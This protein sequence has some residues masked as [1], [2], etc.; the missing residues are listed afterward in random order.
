LVLDS[1]PI[2]THK[3]AL[4]LERHEVRLQINSAFTGSIN[5]NACA[6][7]LHAAVRQM[8]RDVIKGYA[9][10]YDSTH[11]QYVAAARIEFA[12]EHDLALASVTMTSNFHEAATDRTFKRAN[13]VREKHKSVIEYSNDREI[14]NLLNS[15]DFIRNLIY[16]RADFFLRF[17]HSE[18]GSHCGS[19]EDSAD[20]NR[21]IEARKIARLGISSCAA[22][23][24][25]GGKP[26][27]QM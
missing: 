24:A 25:D 15:A 6:Q 9:R 4:N 27:D 3:P 26:G 19:S 16:T 18:I 21:T 20:W 12:C 2:A 13:Q 14:A 17:Y 7:G 1:Q 5:Q 22:N 8:P 23:F 10:C 11:K